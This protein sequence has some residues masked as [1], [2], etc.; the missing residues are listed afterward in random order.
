[1]TAETVTLLV[2]AIVAAGILWA[3]G[4]TSWKGA[5]TRLMLAGLVACLVIQGANG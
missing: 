5:L 3:K 1:M 2:V 4:A